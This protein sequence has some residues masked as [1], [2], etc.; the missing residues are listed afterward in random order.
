MLFQDAVN[1]SAAAA[2]ALSDIDK[3]FSTYITAMALGSCGSAVDFWIANTTAVPTL[4]PIRG[5]VG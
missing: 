1:G 4:A 2:C 5:V 3:E